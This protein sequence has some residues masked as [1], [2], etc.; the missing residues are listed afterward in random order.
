MKLRLRIQPVRILE[1]S[2]WISGLLL[3]AYIAA[4]QYDAWSFNQP[5]PLPSLPAESE[6]PK[7]WSGR[8]EIPRL[9]VSARILEGTDRITLQRGIGHISSTPLPGEPGNA[10]LAAHRDSFFRPLLNVLIGDE[11]VVSTPSGDYHYQVASTRIVLPTDLSVLEPSATE[12]LTLITCFP[13]HYI[14]PAPQRFI[15]IA[16]RIASTT[17]SHLTKLSQ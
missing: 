16:T 10:V 3:F 12:S 2:L 14:G 13:F 4:I 9:T 6:L 1:Y 11:I 15:V 5:E 7:L 17:Q 8:L